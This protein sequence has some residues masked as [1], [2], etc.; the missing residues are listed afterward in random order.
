VKISSPYHAQ[1]PKRDV[2]TF[3]RMWDW[4]REWLA[5]QG[6]YVRLICGHFEDLN[7]NGILPITAFNTDKGKR[8]V[9]MCWDC[10]EHQYV[11]RASDYREVLGWEPLPA[12]PEEPQY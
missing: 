6:R 8:R 4:R 3:T 9:V 11:D 1:G 7:R 5:N 12:M 2:S 10:G